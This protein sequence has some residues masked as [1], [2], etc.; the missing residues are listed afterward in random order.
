MRILR[1]PG[2]CPWDRAQTHQTLRP[3]LLEEAYEALE[4]IDQGDLAALREEMGDL[5]LQIVFHARM[6]EEAGHWTLG[7][8]IRGIREK[9]LERHPHVF[10][11]LKLSTPDQVRD[12][13]EKIKLRHNGGNEERKSTLGG[14]PRILPSL[15]RA[16]RVQEKM[17]GVGFDWPDA[18]G[19]IDKLREELEETV[20]AVLSRD[21]DHAEEEI[22]DLLFSVVN[23]ARLSGFSAEDALRRST[24][25]VIHRFQR[26]EQ[27]A[28]REGGRLAG[29]SLEEMDRYWEKAKLEEQQ[30]RLSGKP[31]ES[32]E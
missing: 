22:G 12:E 18:T 9:M 28:E 15:T 21:R 32:G 1:E 20:E 11:D 30:E 27:L 10:G 23:A 29:L 6:A 24:D 8:V 25:K 7:D 19:A 4:A 5:L 31:G 13:W 16:F 17:A 2:G 26:M 3:Y 14:V